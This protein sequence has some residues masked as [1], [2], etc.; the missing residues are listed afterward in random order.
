MI[1]C[2]IRTGNTSTCLLRM[3]ISTEAASAVALWIGSRQRTVVGTIS[4]E[5]LQTVHALPTFK[6]ANVMIAENSP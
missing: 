2:S 5:S 6:L 4:T 3:G 1:M